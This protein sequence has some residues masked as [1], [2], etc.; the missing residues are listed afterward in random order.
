MIDLNTEIE[1]F[2]IKIVNLNIKV[3]VFTKKIIIS[4]IFELVKID[5]NSIYIEIALIELKT[6]ILLYIILLKFKI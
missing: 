3:K 4:F 5:S 1:V 2:A 6:M